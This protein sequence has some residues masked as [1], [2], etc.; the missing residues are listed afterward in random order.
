[1]RT[2]RD[3]GGSVSSAAT[4]VGHGVGEFASDMSRRFTTWRQRNDS[5]DSDTSNDDANGAPPAE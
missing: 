1:M 2:L 4:A 3:V 5:H